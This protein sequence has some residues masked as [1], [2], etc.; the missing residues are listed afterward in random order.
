MKKIFTL[1]AIAAVACSFAL[2]SCTKTPEDYAKELVSLNK[3]LAEAKKSGDKEKVK[4][5]TE[6]LDQLSK[7]INA[8]END[9]EFMDAFHKA[10]QE[11]LK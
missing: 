1:A 9:K 3:E 6:E 8:K 5:I 2:T 4:E 7:E 10:W 11:A